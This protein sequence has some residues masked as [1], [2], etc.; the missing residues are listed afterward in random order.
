MQQPAL[1]VVQVVHRRGPALLRV[2]LALREAKQRGRCLWA[3]RVNRALGIRCRSGAWGC[4]P[5]SSALVE[6]VAVAVHFQDM[7]M[8]CQTIQQRPGQALG[9]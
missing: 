1:R 4:F 5:F 2:A 8:V 9:T 3:H 6:P 7:D